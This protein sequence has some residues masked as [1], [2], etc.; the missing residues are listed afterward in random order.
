L[1]KWKESIINLELE[2]KKLYHEMEM[3]MHPRKG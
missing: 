3:A 1:E 2:I